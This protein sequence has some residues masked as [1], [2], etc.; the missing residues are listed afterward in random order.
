MERLLQDL[1]DAANIAAAG[2]AVRRVRVRVRELLADVASHP[3]PLLARKDIRFRVD[4]IADDPDVLCDPDRLTQVFSNLLGNA[5]K[6][7]R[8]GGGV[9]L[10]AQLAP[11]EVVFSVSDTG[12]GIAEALLPHVFDRH[13]RGEGSNGGVGLGLYICKA[14]VEAHGGRI[15]VRSEPGSGTVFSFSVPR[16][17]GD[18]GA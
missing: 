7:T 4:P 2:L 14:I 11:G 13:A 6:F 16:F 10:Q 17:E 9:T 5:S 18:L 1:L 8:P 3:P 15:W 12:S